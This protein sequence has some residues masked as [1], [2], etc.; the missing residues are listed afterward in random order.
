MDPSQLF[1]IYTNLYMILKK[2]NIHH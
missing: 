2:N 1:F